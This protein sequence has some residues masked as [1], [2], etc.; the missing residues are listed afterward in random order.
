MNF[1]QGVLDSFHDAYGTDEVRRRLW[2][3]RQECQ[4]C[5]LTISGQQLVGQGAVDIITLCVRTG[6]IDK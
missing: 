6:Q 1:G 2:L 4:S 3:R 5:E